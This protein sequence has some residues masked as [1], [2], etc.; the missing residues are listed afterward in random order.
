[1]S[2]IE[3]EV[4]VD[5]PPE[6]VW[7]VVADPRNLPRWDRRVVA[8]RD[9]P[10]GG[11][12]KGSGYVVELRFMGV[13]AEVEARVLDLEPNEYAK[14][15]LAGMAEATIETW[16]RPHGSGRSRLRHR[17]DYSFKGGALGEFAA[18]AVRML[19]AQGMLKRG[20]A[21]QKRQVESGS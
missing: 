20:L 13:R 11:L 9:V 21:T 19:G 16:V 18:R 3:A 14:V 12:G 7:A 17:I 2:V 5:A 6:R 8:V 15:R 1:V 10:A 4:V